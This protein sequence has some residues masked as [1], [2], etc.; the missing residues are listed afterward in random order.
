MVLKSSSS[1][2]PYSFSFAPQGT[3]NFVSFSLTTLPF[4][5][6]CYQLFN[7]INRLR[8]I[9]NCSIDYSISTGCFT[10]RHIN[11]V[12]KYCTVTQHYY[13]PH[14]CWASFIHAVTKHTESTGTSTQFQMFFHRKERPFTERKHC[15]MQHCI[16]TNLKRNILSQQPNTIF[17]VNL[18]VRAAAADEKCSFLLTTENRK[19][20]PCSCV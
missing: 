6:T 2:F 8:K 9:L 16:S 13:M 7:Y 19:V 12:S 10:N 3:C 14:S 1:H 5:L 15:H 17:E 11:F 20:M 4:L 18:R